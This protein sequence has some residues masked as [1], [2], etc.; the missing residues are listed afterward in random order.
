MLFTTLKTTIVPPLLSLPD[1]VTVVTDNGFDAV[2]MDGDATAVNEVSS[3]TMER[4]VSKHGN[5]DEQRHEEELLDERQCHY[6]DSAETV[7]GLS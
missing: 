5:C 2:I 1:R 7:L 3:D 6:V 4:P